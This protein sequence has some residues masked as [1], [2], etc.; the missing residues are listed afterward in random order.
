MLRRRWPLLLL[1]LTAVI[2][3]VLIWRV[4]QTRHT[5]RVVSAVITAPA[6]DLGPRAHVLLPN[7]RDAV[8]VVPDRPHDPSEVQAEDRF[9]RIRRLR[10]FSVSTSSQALRGPELG[11]K[12]G[13]RILCLGDSVTFG[14]G[15]AEAETYPARLADLL[16]V[17]VINAGV[18]AMKPGSIARWAQQHAAA[19]EP[20][21][22]LLA[23]RPDYSSPD[24]WR[25][26]QQALQTVRA[27]IG[28]A[29]LGVLLPPVSTFDPRGIAAMDEELARITQLASPAPVLDLTPTFR[30][31]LPLPGVVLEQA[32]AEQRLV[33]LPGGT[34]LISAQ[35]PPLA[36][37]QPALAQPI[38]DAFENDKAV[39]EPLF[40]DGG[41]PDAAGFVLFARAVAD[42]IQ[43][44]GLL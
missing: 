34:L 13:P 29:R 24:P 11:P 20:D 18:P 28:T 5:E 25:D 3:A 12:S 36:P 39:Q 37:G 40:F 14:W 16:H 21:L 27:S 8:V 23:S 10:T 38:I 26:Y 35:A 32:G 42:W 15:V 22:V 30:A 2:S 31:A 9:E 17:E 19:L 4:Q 6:P 33:R 43:A 41:H 1:L 7:L 44:E